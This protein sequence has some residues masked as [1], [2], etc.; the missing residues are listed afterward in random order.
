MGP[1]LMHGLG[2][3][4][5]QCQLD[6]PLTTVA[7]DDVSLTSVAGCQIRRRFHELRDSEQIQSRLPNFVFSCITLPHNTARCD[8]LPRDRHEL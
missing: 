8:Q 3:R 6:F 5:L 2:S 4:T 1:T 7:A